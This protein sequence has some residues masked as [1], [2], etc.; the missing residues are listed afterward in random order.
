MSTHIQVARVINPA[1]NPGE[2]QWNDAGA[3]GASPNLFWDNPNGRLSI[4][5]GTAPE[6]RLDIRAQG[7]LS[8]DIAFRVRN[9]ADTADIFSVNGVGALYSSLNNI[10][11]TIFINST[12]PSSLSSNNIALNS[13]ILGGGNKTW[14]IVLNGTLAQSGGSETGKVRINTNSPNATDIVIGKHGV[15]SGQIVARGD[16]ITIGNNISIGTGFCAIG[17]NMNWFG[18][19]NSLG[20]F[21]IGTSLPNLINNYAN[22]MVFGI[23]QV[24]LVIGGGKGNL[25]I[26][27]NPT[28]RAETN[29][30]FIKSGTAPITSVV[31][32]FQQYSDDITAGNAAPHFRTENGSVIKLYQETTTIASSSFVANTSTILDDSAT[33]DGYTMGQVVKA[34]RNLG[35][36]A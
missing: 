17:S 11:N 13:V 35:I 22:A 33:F 27:Y 9:S 12:N 3:F 28:G 15:G 1:G 7:A 2:I 20:L 31:D 10:E 29:T 4:G 23:N 14:N 5:Q 25:G 32:A 16:K 30:F 19:G 6:A 36:L 34:L 18:G 21:A 8:T 24:D 26:N